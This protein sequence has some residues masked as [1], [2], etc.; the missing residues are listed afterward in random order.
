MPPAWKD[1]Q[2]ATAAFY[3]ELGLSAETDVSIDGVRGEH[4]VDVAVR[5]HRAGVE[6]L[7]IVECKF[8]DR[9]V[10]KAT[11][12]TLSAIMLD[13]GADRGIILSRRGFQSGAPA[14]AQKNNMTLTS[15]EQLKEDTK[16]EYIERQCDR[17]CQR[18][19]SILTALHSSQLEKLRNPDDNPLDWPDIV[20]GARAGALKTAT[21]EAVAGRWPVGITHARDGREGYAFPDNMTDFLAICD[22]VLSELEDQLAAAAAVAKQLN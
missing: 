9:R 11:V 16:G 10:P 14:M 15:L 12:A 3:R 21:T 4:S 8:W 13:V 17:I 20:I 19:D 2:E 6:F 7:W 18:C 22:I 5:G 1:Y